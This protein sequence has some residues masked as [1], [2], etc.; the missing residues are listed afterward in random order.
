MFQECELSEYSEE[1]KQG[2]K[3]DA[4]LPTTA[5]VVNRILSQCCDN[6]QVL[7][8]SDI[9]IW[10]KI[11]F[12]A[13]LSGLV[14][15]KIAYAADA[16]ESFLQ[17]TFP[18]YLVPSSISCETDIELD[19]NSKKEIQPFV[20]GIIAKLQQIA[21]ANGKHILNEVNPHLNNDTV[22]GILGF[23]VDPIK[24]CGVSYT[25]FGKDYD[26]IRYAQ[27][28]SLCN[29]INAIREIANLPVIQIDNLESTFKPKLEDEQKRFAAATAGY[30]YAVVSK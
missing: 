11:F 27:A 2:K 7:A 30:A 13:V 10:T 22:F 3:S 16:L 24:A 28:Q 5:E 25:R 21:S 18:N 8:T 23:K 19:Q 14:R 1:K 12:K 20:A 15:R 6:S 9:E 29:Y 17:Q 4:T 26:S